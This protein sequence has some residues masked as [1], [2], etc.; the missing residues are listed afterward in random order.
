ML[1]RERKRGI[2]AA[3]DDEDEEAEDADWGALLI[4]RVLLPE[5]KWKKKI[6]VSDVGSV[7]QSEIFD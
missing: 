5:I 6:Q 3:I 1:P 2:G 7:T 4:D